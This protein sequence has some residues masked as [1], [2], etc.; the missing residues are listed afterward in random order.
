MGGQEPGTRLAAQQALLS[1]G[2]R[3]VR[4]LLRTHILPLLKKA[5]STPKIFKIQPFDLS[6][7][8]VAGG[9]HHCEV[10]KTAVG[11]RTRPSRFPVFPSRGLAAAS[12]SV[13]ITAGSHGRVLTVIRPGDAVAGNVFKDP[14]ESRADLGQHPLVLGTT[15]F[16][17]RGFCHITVQVKDEGGLVVPLGPDAAIAGSG[18]TWSG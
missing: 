12:G 4:E 16:Q 10:G 3:W 1:P 2:G 13:G 5:G 7:G 17:R 18:P 15:P 11:M 14:R 6:H 8:V 9:T